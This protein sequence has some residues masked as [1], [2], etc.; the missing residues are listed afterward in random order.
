MSN[1]R[2][3]ET[4]EKPLVVLQVTLAARMGLLALALLTLAGMLV[5]AKPAGAATTS[6]IP[7]GDV[8]ALKSA[9]DAANQNA[10]PDTITLAPEGTYTLTQVDNDFFGPNGLP[11]IRSEIIIEGNGSKITRSLAGQAPDFRL[12]YVW[13]GG[14]L[15]LRDVELSGGRAVGGDGA[16]SSFKAGA[17]GGAAG[18]GGAIFNAGTLSVEGS[19]LH[20]NSA[21][22]GMGGSYNQG[23]F[24]NPQG[25]GGGGV[26]GPAYLGNGGPG[27]YEEPGGG[28]WGWA[29]YPSSICYW[30]GARAPN[31]G[32]GGPGGGGGAGHDFGEGGY[33]GFGGGGG[34]GGYQGGR[35]GHGGGYSPYETGSIGSTG[36]SG[37]GGGGGGGGNMNP[38]YGESSG[39]PGVGGFGG[40]D[41]INGSGGGGG[42]FGGAI[43]NHDGTLTITNS[44]VYGNEVMGGF[45]GYGMI[46]YGG[47]TP[48]PGEHGIGLGGGLFNRN[49][50]VTIQ[51]STFTDNYANTWASE[52]VTLPV[53][54]P[55]GTGAGIY[56]LGNYETGVKLTMNDT[57]VANNAGAPP[58]GGS[59][60]DYELHAI[61]GGAFGEGGSNLIENNGDDGWFSGTVTA[62]PKLGPFQDNG[63]PTRT[64]ALGFGSPA[65]DAAG[66]DCPATDGRGVA[67][68]Q[69]GDDDGTKLCD[70]GAFEV[71]PPPNDAFAN[72][73]TVSGDKASVGG[74]NQAATREPGEPNHFPSPFVGGKSVWYSWM[75]SDAGSVTLDTCTSDF[76]TVLAVYSGGQLDALSQVIRVDNGCSSGSGSKVTFDARA[77]T[78]YKIA[79]ATLLADGVGVFQLELAFTDDVAPA[80][81]LITS[82]A[83]NSYD[84]DGTIAFSG[85]AEAN[86]TVKIF[87]G[88]TLKGTATAGTGGSWSKTLTGVANGRHAYTARA[89]DKAGNT[90][91]ASASKTVTVDTIKP[92]VLD[93]TSPL[94]GATGVSPSANVTA[95]FSEAMNAN[96]LR[97]ATTSR[98]TTFTLARRNAD[99]TRT[100]IAA[101]VSYA[102]TTTATGGKVYRATLNPDA[103]LQLGRTYV[104]TV[105]TG[106]RDAAGNPLDQSPTLAGNQPKTWS[107]KVRP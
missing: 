61:N 72:A 104:A 82:P 35:G 94:G 81:P 71:S 24:P 44:T 46:P 14:N 30:S 26:A 20:G 60:N 100:L 34:G 33:G 59:V 15:T 66:A 88:T 78:T 64:S 28:C 87:E 73:E 80:A 29:L 4:V 95:T 9:I 93:P 55:A 63:G 56:H 19:A 52:T 70:I 39:G 41:G 32:N 97:N 37:F 69:D 91:A 85:T 107:F 1:R 27:N 84:L 8:A 42:G 106:A 50:A 10:G 7:D 31:G 45:G 98:S 105:T 38:S 23:N 54:M 103:N 51:S 90:S 58:N 11:S 12:F 3:F 86:A 6:T 74:T 57:I 48:I 68:P 49:G 92:K 2:S 76:D 18:M 65:I 89:T 16:N 99:G 102:V 47:S 17:G 96:T 21:W 43:F 77:N 22:G 62:D 101:K 36:G 5:L 53:G 79:V 13:P 40:G 75:A 67:R 25:G 83:D